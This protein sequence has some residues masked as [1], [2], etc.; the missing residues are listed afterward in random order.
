MVQTLLFTQPQSEAQS[1][2]H[3][4]QVNQSNGRMSQVIVPLSNGAA[5]P[6]PPRSCPP[7]TPLQTQSR[8]PLLPWALARWC[9]I[10]KSQLV[11]LTR[12]APEGAPREPKLTAEVSGQGFGEH[13]RPP[14]GSPLGAPG[15][16]VGPAA[17]WAQCIALL[18][19]LSPLASATL[20]KVMM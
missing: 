18:P 5:L 12:K 13:Q 19:T 14:G 17:S 16:P 3:E 2:G 1:Q 11:F 4:T 20:E 9:H 6:P 15:Q 8:V 10:L 7:E